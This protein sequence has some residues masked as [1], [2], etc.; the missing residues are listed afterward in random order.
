M[1]KTQSDSIPLAV[2]Q[3]NLLYISL[4]GSLVGLMAA[5]MSFVSVWVVRLGASP[6]WISLL[7]SAPAAIALLMALPWSRFAERQRH[8]QKVFAFGR[9]TYHMVYPLLAIV[10]LFLDDEWTARVVVVLWTLSAF[11]RSLTQMM[12]TIVMGQAV[13]PERRAFLMSRRWTFLGLAKLIALTVAGQILDLLPF[14]T[15]YQAMYGFNTLLI[16]PALYCALRIRVRERVPP[17]P[18]PRRSWLTGLREQVAEVWKAKAFLAFVGGRAAFGLGMT[19]AAVAVPIY[20]VHHLN[21]SDAWVGYFNAAL[22]AATLVSYMPWVRIKNAL[23]TRWMMIAATL[24]RAAYPAMLA[25]TRAPIGVLA[26]VVLGG[27]AIGGLNLGFFD[28][29]LDTSPPDKRERFV[30]LNITAVNL[31]GIIG[32]SI[33]AA[34][35]GVMNIRSVLLVGTLVAMSGVVLLTLTSGGRRKVADHSNRA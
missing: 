19:M 10:P 11:P 7:S 24:L 29:L 25:L 22:S 18:P 27:L 26:V 6:F 31:T 35:L 8:P 30:A 9:L 33:G 34:L 4:D 17:P 21:V 28:T 14:P 16:A 32:P 20:W 1:T 3:H 15:G 2:Q 12:F 5:G 23:G 13:S